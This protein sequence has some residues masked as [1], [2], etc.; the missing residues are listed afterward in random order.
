MPQLTTA[1]AA[2]VEAVA[3]PAEPIRPPFD[4]R[5]CAVE[6]TER[7]AGLG[8]IRLLRPMIEREFPGRIAVVSSFGADSAVLLALVAQVDPATPVI[9]L[10]TGKHFPETLGYRDELTSRLGLRDVRSIRPEAVQ[11]ERHDPEGALWRRD[12]DFCCHLRKVLPLKR[13]LAG[14]DAW[15][16]GRKRFQDAARAALPPIEV[17]GTRIKINP[18]AGWS[19]DQLEA[20][21]EVAGLPRHP[22]VEDGYPSIGCE[23]CTR[24]P[25]PGAGPRSGRWAGHNKT[26]CGI[27][28]PGGEGI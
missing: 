11:L 14:F 28:W 10:E 24:R 5:A 16:T 3:L 19:A 12:P 6:L 7:Y 1:T 15:V 17:D 20:G 21:L 4:A 25:A 22:L 9:F 26:E 13:A 18:L 8:G 2:T 23:P 27:H